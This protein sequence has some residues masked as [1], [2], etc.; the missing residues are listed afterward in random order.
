MYGGICG[1]IDTW[2]TDTIQISNSYNIGTL[3]VTS[4]NA[5]GIIGSP[6]GNSGVSANLKIENCYNS[7]IF[8]YTVSKANANA[9]SIAKSPGTKTQIYYLNTIDARYLE[10]ESV[11]IDSTRLA[12]TEFAEELGD[13][14][15]QSGKCYPILKWQQQ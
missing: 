6:D 5:G 10:T 12:S 4:G 8:K 2:H 13:L 3:I 14:W 15:V 9:Y 1:K 11:E 7:G